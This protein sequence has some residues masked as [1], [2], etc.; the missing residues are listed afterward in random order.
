MHAYGLIIPSTTREAVRTQAVITQSPY[1][2]RIRSG[3]AHTAV[4]YFAKAV[5]EL[6]D[7]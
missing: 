7:E 3:V 6:R 2:T 4:I 5:L 1:T